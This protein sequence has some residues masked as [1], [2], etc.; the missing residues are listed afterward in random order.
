MDDITASII[1]SCQTSGAVASID[2]LGFSLAMLG[3]KAFDFGKQAINEF[4]ATQ[5]AAWKFSRVFK[6]TMGT[7]DKA[8]QDFMESYNLSEQTARS[9]LGDTASVLKG[10]GMSE[11]AALSMSE[12]V[13]RMGADLASYT[14]YAGGAKGAT[15]AI[16]A[17]MLGETERLKSLGTVIS[18]DSKEFKDLTQNMIKTKGVSEQQARAMA[19]LELVTKKNADAVGDAM[20]EGENLTQSINIWS[21]ASKQATS[22]IGGLLYEVLGVNDAVGGLGEQLKAINNWWKKSGKEITYA[23]RTV[24]IDIGTVGELAADT[25]APLFQS[26]AVGFEN[27]ITLGDWFYQ[28]WS[29]MWD[30]AGNIAIG[31]FKD[32][33]EYIKWF[34]GPDGMI[35]G[36]FVTAGKSIWKALKA[37]LTGGNVAEVFAQEWNKYLDNNVI[38]GFAKQGNNTDKALAAAGVS[39]L[40]EL[41]N[42]DWDI[43]SRYNKTL[44]KNEKKQKAAWERYLKSLEPKR[45]NKI[46]E[47]Q[48][49]AA[50]APEQQIKALTAFYRDMNQYRATTQGAIMSGSVEAMRLR[51]RQMVNTSTN[52]PAAATAKNTQKQAELLM[53]IAEKTNEM[54]N[55]LNQITGNG[56]KIQNLA[57]RTF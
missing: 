27:I 23:V 47:T 28:N 4:R 33:W 6:N 25:F 36:F 7:A 8:V 10:A 48:Q 52:N 46:E 57:V 54:I 3:K 49:A 53:Q 13:A 50:V 32:L 9:M 45:D 22:N 44:D 35:T 12:K 42:V 41:K 26:V 16:T 30:N 20:A 38:G 21:E 24:L 40:P 37:G 34:W 19:V 14:G 29:K 2:K 18:M 56:V 1:V 11:K 55:K 17:A 31:V 51:S 15:E 39:K 43:I 5:D